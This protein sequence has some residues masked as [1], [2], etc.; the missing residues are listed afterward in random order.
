MVENNLEDPL[1]ALVEDL[2]GLAPPTLQTQNFFSK[3]DEKEPALIV[4]ADHNDD[5]PSKMENGEGS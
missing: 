1:T 2:V 3:T 5:L 4:V